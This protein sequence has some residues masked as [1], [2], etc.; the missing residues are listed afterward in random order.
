MPIVR[1]YMSA[2]LVYVAEGSRPRVALQPM[3]ELGVATVPVLDESHRP[4]GVV[5]M[6]DLIDS[7]EAPK[8][9]TPVKTILDSATTEEAAREMVEAN[10]HHLIVVN[11]QGIAVGMLSALDLVRASIGAK[12]KHP[13]Q[14]EKI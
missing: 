11:A 1:D 2:R 4:V 9:S 3:L 6:R 12:P 8:I 5:S 14:L 10:I 13:S 7:H